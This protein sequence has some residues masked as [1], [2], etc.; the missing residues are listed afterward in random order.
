[1]EL[2][3]KTKNKEL[4]EERAS[5]QLSNLELIIQKCS[6]KK[7]IRDQAL[8]SNLMSNLLLLLEHYLQKE[9]LEGQEEANIKNI[10]NIIY[11]LIPKKSSMDILVELDSIIDKL[12]LV[13]QKFECLNGSK[14]FWAIISTRL[15]SKIS[16]SRVNLILD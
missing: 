2:E 7:D 16:D 10:V 8:D 14:A 6:T 13:K 5:V 15:D 12:V 4:N 9:K 11:S 3:S 1:M